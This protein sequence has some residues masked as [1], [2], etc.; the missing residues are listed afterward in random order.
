M[1]NVPTYHNVI[2]N[3]FSI[4]AF[5]NAYLHPP[6]LVAAEITADELAQIKAI[7]RIHDINYKSINFGEFLLRL[8]LAF[9]LID[10]I[11]KKI[12]FPPSP[13][14]KSQKSM[15]KSTSA[16]QCRLAAFAFFLTQAVRQL[17]VSATAIAPPGYNFVDF[18]LHF[19]AR[20]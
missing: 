17:V 14:V 3:I 9:P 13:I 4:F 5:Q 18:T 12:V 19:Y 2:I 11:P 10:T 7:A 6:R 16:R 8:S 1:V 15:F 20:R